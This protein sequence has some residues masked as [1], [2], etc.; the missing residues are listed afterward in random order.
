MHRLREVYIFSFISLYYISYTI[1]L[2][3]LLLQHDEW[4]A[5]QQPLM[6]FIKLMTTPPLYYKPKIW[7]SKTEELLKESQRKLKGNI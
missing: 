1:N 7:T 4:A 6:K 3:S 2:Y 5:R